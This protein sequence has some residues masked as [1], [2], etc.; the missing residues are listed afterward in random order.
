VIDAVSRHRSIHPFPARMAPEVALDKIES[1]TKSGALVLDPMCGSGTVPLL[2]GE[3]GRRAIACDV[4]PLAV[5]ITRTAC[6][7][8]WSDDLLA[9]A[10]ELITASKRFHSTLPPWIARDDESREFVE[11]WFDSPQRQALSQIAKVLSQRPSMDDPLRIAL[12]RLIVTKEGGAS[13]ARDTSHSRPHRVQL[14]S[15]FDVHE[16][17]LRSAEKVEKLVG[18]VR[19]KH[20]PSV[21]TADARSLAF[22]KRGSVDLV[23]TSP[24]YLNA[25][26]YIRGHRLSLVWLGYRIGE[27]RELRGDSIGAERGLHKPSDEVVSMVSQ[28]VPGLSELGDRD[29]RMVWRF[30]KDVDRLCRSLARVTRAEGHLVFVVADSQLRGVPVSNSALCRIIAQQNGFTFQESVIRPL[31]AHHRYLPPP[32]SGSSTLSVRMREEAVLT[33][34]R[35]A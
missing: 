8:A 25:I 13:L 15:D 32:S 20:L 17:F 31:P 33:F 7:P 6:K 30:A 26:D 21:R 11:Y 28:A 22:L 35:A 34:Q 18:E 1:L 5:M 27:L 29:Q 12:S 19:P 24:P 14:T 16:A 9:R 23:V 3:E 2:A 4:D 10:K